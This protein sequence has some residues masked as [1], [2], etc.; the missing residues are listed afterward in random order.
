MDNINKKQPLAMYYVMIFLTL[1][2]HVALAASLIGQQES[3]IDQIGEMEQGYRR[4]SNLVETK[5]TA[6]TVSTSP[7]VMAAAAAAA[8][9][10]AATTVQAVTVGGVTLNSG[11]VTLS[12]AIQANT[13]L[14]QDLN[15]LYG[16]S[17][18]ST[19]PATSWDATVLNNIT[20]ATNYNQTAYLA[21]LQTTNDLYKSLQANASLLN[22]FNQLYKT[23]LPVTGSPMTADVNVLF[24]ITADTYYN[25]VNFTNS[26]K[27]LAATSPQAMSLSLALQSNSNYAQNMNLLYGTSFTSTGAKTAW[28]TTVLTR[29]TTTANYDRTA[30]VA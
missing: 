15:L 24:G 8:P 10:A 6:L 23:F 12:Q 26:V 7:M 4:S 30:Y 25:Q 13:T 14:M 19:G 27:T 22:S 16:T 29:I 2:S 3:T 21:S 1:H 5:N 9:L 11:A 20:T 17:F 18:K 28:D